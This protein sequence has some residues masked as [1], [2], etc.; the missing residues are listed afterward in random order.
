LVKH[1]EQIFEVIDKFMP[2]EVDLLILST[3]VKPGK[4]AC[5]QS[6]QTSSQHQLAT[7]RI[8]ASIKLETT[9]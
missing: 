7:H 1:P 4:K 6:K 9:E 8:D 3:L 2:I 5:Q